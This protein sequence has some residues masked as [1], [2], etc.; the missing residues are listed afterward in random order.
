MIPNSF[1]QTKRNILICVLNWGLGHATRMIPII[2]K[3]KANGSKIIICADGLAYDFLSGEFPNLDFEKLPGYNIKY[4]SRWNALHLAFQAWKIPRAIRKE[5]KA[6]Y[7]LIKKHKPDFILSDNRYGCYSKDID[8]IILTHQTHLFVNKWYHVFPN[9]FLDRQ[10]ANFD[11]VW[12]PDNDKQQ[13]SGKLSTTKHPKVNFIGPLS[14]LE[15]TRI[16][17]KTDILVILSGIEPQRSLLEERLLELNLEQKYSVKWIRGTKAPSKQTINKDIE[18]VNLAQREVLNQWMNESKLVITRCGY[19]S[20]MDLV[21]MQQQAMLIPTPGQQEQIY[22]GKHLADHALFTV[23]N[24]DD[25]STDAGN[26]ISELIN[27]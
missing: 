16:K 9:A 20:V 11:E 24:Q 18:V 10:L 25:L 4:A 6:I 26:L 3:C 23:V 27:N 22:L 15:K 2:E 21:S 19:S 14:S 1:L 5:Q 8:S 7:R 13:L 17:K 12:I